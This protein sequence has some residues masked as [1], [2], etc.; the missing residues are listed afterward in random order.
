MNNISKGAVY[1]FRKSTEPRR[2]EH[3]HVII[4][5]SGESVLLGTITSQIQDRRDRADAR[6]EHP[7]TVVD[8][9]PCNCSCLKHPSVVDC[10]FPY[11]ITLDKL[12]ELISGRKVTYRC[13]ICTTLLDSL[14]NGVDKSKSAPNKARNLLLY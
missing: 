9:A 12:R 13:K 2:D 10:N 7:C 5:L 6:D 4:A 1:Y 3:L 14:R 8:I 11:C